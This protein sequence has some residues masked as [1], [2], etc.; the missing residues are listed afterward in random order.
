M[1]QLA[2]LALLLPL[3]VPSRSLLRRRKPQQGKEPSER[4]YAHIFLQGAPR[5]FD[6]NKLNFLQ[7]WGSTAKKL[8][9]QALDGMSTGCYS[10]C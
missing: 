1:E 9:L 6:D 5:P 8:V 7:L 2:F 3:S 10:I 4:W